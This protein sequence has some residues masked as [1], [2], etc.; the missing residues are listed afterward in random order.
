L[1]LGNALRSALREKAL[2]LT[3]KERSAAKKHGW[4]A[5]YSLGLVFEGLSVEMFTNKYNDLV[6]SCSEAI[7]Y[8][9]L[10][11]K[12]YR[13]LNEKIVLASMIALCKLSN[14]L[15][16]LNDYDGGYTGDALISCILLHHNL[17]EHNV[18]VSSKLVTQNENLL[19]HL[20]HSASLKTAIKVLNDEYI[21]T[22]I[23]ES[24]YLWMV[25]QPLPS[26][27]FEIFANAFQQGKSWSD[28]SIEQ[29]FASRAVQ[30]YKQARL[31]DTIS[32]LMDSNE[33]DEL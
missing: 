4:G 26:S 23:M 13:N 6:L 30:K 20:L 22:N 1:K 32:V 17:K 15:L 8:L 9:V 2:K 3:W 24:M 16:T 28:V 25:D 14:N 5:C 7:R 19:R 29:R 33:G 12:N 27:A 21:T 31:S 10:C 18:T 11:S